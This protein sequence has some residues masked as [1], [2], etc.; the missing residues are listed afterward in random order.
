MNTKDLKNL[1]PNSLEVKAKDLTNN[2]KNSMLNGNID[3]IDAFMFLKKNAKIFETLYEDKKIK[4]LLQTEFDNNKEKKSVKR[5]GQRITQSDRA[6]YDYSECGDPELE[7][8]YKIQKQVKE[9]IKNREN[10]LKQL[11]QDNSSKEISFGIKKPE[12]VTNVEYNL[13]I[14]E[15]PTDVITVNPPIKYG[16]TSLSFFV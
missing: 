5:Y 7:E 4:E 10:Q 13:E 16:K 9:L 14:K 8:L 3:I 2:I 11:H 15:V 1:T 6:N 12:I